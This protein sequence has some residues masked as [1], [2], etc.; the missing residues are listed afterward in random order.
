MSRHGLRVEGRTAEE[1]WRDAERIPGIDRTAIRE[2]LEIY[3]A[4]RFGERRLEPKR[5]RVLKAR[6]RQAMRLEQ[7]PA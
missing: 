1:L 2:V 3:L 4:S 7:R 6:I 5:Y